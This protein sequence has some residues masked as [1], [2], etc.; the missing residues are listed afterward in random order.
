MTGTFKPAGAA[1]AAVVAGI[2]APAGLVQAADAAIAEREAQA[3][4]LVA[5]AKAYAAAE[6]LS[7]TPAQSDLFDL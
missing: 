7:E 3:D 5:A 2:A 6:P 4:A 1:F